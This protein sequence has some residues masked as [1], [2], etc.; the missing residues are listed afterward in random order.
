[1]QD[2]LVESDTTLQSL[3]TNSNLDFSPV[4]LSS[5]FISCFVANC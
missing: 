2:T 3:I 5:C 4:L 1:M